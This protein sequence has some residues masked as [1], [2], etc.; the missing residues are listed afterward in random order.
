[1]HGKYVAPMALFFFVAQNIFGKINTNVTVIWFLQFD[2]NNSVYPDN[3]PEKCNFWV[4]M[5]MVTV[6]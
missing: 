3:F 1:M 4:K 6:A 5:H 2:S